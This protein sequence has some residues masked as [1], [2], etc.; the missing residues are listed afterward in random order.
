MGQCVPERQALAP[1]PPIRLRLPGSNL[2]L[3]TSEHLAPVSAGTEVPVQTS[4]PPAREHSP[5]PVLRICALP[6][7]SP[8]CGHWLPWPQQSKHLGAG[9]SLWLVLTGCEVVGNFKLLPGTSRK[10][11]GPHLPA[12]SSLTCLGLPHSTCVELCL[13]VGT[14]SLL[15]EPAEAGTSLLGLAQRLCPRQ[16]FPDR[17]FPVPKPCGFCQ[18][19][20]FS[21]SQQM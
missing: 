10:W 18:A 8:P 19:L 21:S 12:C 14:P 20:G 6:L 7:A 11:P 16:M 5:D 3:L 17:P 13:M 1:P 4:Q 15:L 9:E 2:G